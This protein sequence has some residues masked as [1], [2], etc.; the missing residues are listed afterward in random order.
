[1]T[2]FYSDPARE[3]EPHALPDAEVFWADAGDWAYDERGERCDY[4]EDSVGLT[5]CEA[6]YYFWACFPGCL[7][8]SEPTG[9]YATEEEAVQAARDLWGV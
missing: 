9:P 7:P 1:M 4:Y 2:Q 8:D 3:T 5:P 6:G